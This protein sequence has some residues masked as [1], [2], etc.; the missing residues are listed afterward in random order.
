[1]TCE[2]WSILH[3]MVAVRIEKEGCDGLV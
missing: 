2:A 1:M 3:L